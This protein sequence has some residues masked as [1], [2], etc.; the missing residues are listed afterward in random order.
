MSH[1]RKMSG[2][3]YKH[4]RETVSSIQNADYFQCVSDYFTAQANMKLNV[5]HREI[6]KK[7]LHQKN[8]TCTAEG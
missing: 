1:D 4:E 5:L 6:P 7:K 2:C 8:L 3:F